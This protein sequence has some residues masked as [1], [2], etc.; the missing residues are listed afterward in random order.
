GRCNDC[1]ECVPQCPHQALQRPI[2]HGL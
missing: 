2:V 1:G